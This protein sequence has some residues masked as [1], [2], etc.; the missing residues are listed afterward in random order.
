MSITFL[1]TIRSYGRNSQNLFH[2]DP[3][4]Y[5]PRRVIN[6]QYVFVWWEWGLMFFLSCIF[7]YF[8]LL[9]DGQRYATFVAEA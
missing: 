2:S 9:L 1:P 7:I 5:C 3:C 4:F 6:E 8:M